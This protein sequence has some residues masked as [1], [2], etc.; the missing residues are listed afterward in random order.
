VRPTH[1]PPFAAELQ[2][3]RIKLSVCFKAE[4]GLKGIGIYY[5]GK[6]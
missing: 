5:P 4:I 6:V 3:I 2:P 1:I